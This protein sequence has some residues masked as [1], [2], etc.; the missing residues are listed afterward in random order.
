MS[1]LRNL[2]LPKFM[3]ILSCVFIHNLLFPSYLDIKSAWNLL[4]VRL[5][6]CQDLLFSR[7]V[8]N[9]GRDYSFPI[10]L[11][12]HLCH[13][14]VHYLYVILSLNLFHW[15]TCLSLCQPVFITRDLIRSWYMVLLFCSVSMNYFYKSTE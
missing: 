14:L 9:Y 11:Q 13:K 8:S 5:S 15:S 2:H 12:C 7:W 4:C 10:A 6:T 3:M 1:S